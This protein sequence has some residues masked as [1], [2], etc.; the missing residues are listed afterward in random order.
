LQEEAQREMSQRKD[1]FLAS[2]AHELRN[3]LPPIRNA[4]EIMRLSEN[5]PQA[6][7]KG[8]AMIE[9]QLNQL[10]RL[11]DDLLDLSRFTRGKIRLRVGTIDLQSVI[12]A[13]VETSRP[14]IEAAQH[15]LTV[16]VPG[17]PVHFEGDFTR[18][19]QVVV[20]LLNNA[21]KY[22]NPKGEI[23]LSAEVEEDRLVIKVMDNGIGIPPEMIG[24]IFDMFNQGKSTE[25][26][27]Q[28]G[29]GIG[30]ALVRSIVQL[31]GG[32]VIVR[33]AGPGKGSEFIV[34][35]PISH[36]VQIPPSS[37]LPKSPSN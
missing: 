20:N 18:L 19:T 24:H 25:N 35:L 29:L 37:A 26:H 2:M 15:Q 36:P 9:R 13:A 16:L 3:P 4:I 33:S 21:A 1:E 8:R 6:V 17:E 28:G 5:S 7:E 30:L 11:I 14:H 10:I 34:R 31:H 22:T 12:D 32:T 23:I 27:S